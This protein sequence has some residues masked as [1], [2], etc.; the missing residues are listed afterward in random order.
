MANEF[1]LMRAK[2]VQDFD[3]LF[4]IV[5]Q[6]DPVG[7]L[8]SVHYSKVMYDYARPWVTHASLQTTNFEAAE[9]WLQAWRKPIVFDEIMYEGNLNRRW[10]NIS[11][12]E[13][14]RRFWL[15]IIAGC[16]VTHGET[17][18]DPS[19]PLDENTTPTLWW[20][21]GGTLK[22][23]SPARIAFLRKLVEEQSGLE[24][25]A[26]QSYLNASTLDAAGK[27]KEILYFMDFHQPIYFDFPLPEGNYTADMIDPWT[28]KVS[29]VAGKFSGTAKIKLS[30]R[31]YQALRFRRA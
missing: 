4:H 28:M 29:T 6:Y 23:T 31:P 25:G 1:D 16:Y 21:H 22:G 8:R 11:G 10:G 3:R 13:N 19:Q 30:G 5:E 12:E 24:A 7:H 9:G 17:Y 18:L 14:T 20:S 15:C 27:P 2:S 26:T